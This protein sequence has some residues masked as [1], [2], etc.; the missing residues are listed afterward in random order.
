M[1]KEIISQ[2]AKLVHQIHRLRNKN[3][4]QERKERMILWYI[5]TN[6]NCTPHDIAVEFSITPQ[7]V[8]GCINQFESL[9]YI[10]R[11]VDKVDRR[12][13]N[14][15]LTELGKE[16]AE[17]S[18]KEYFEEINALMEFIGE[19]DSLQLIKIYEKIKAYYMEEKE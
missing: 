7:M 12:K 18:T 1:K 14:L 16:Q 8:S 3:A 9:N 2:Y 19:K 17:I 10:Y 15:V 6:D 5:S 13:F 4:I 11:K